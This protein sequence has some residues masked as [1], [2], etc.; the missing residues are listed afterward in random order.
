MGAEKTMIS[1]AV[2]QDE[3]FSLDLTFEAQALYLQLAAAASDSECGL[4][5]TARRAT[6]TLGL[7]DTTLETLVTAGYIIPIPGGRYVLTHYWTANGISTR[8]K[9]R[10]EEIEKAGLTVGQGGEYRTDGTG[11]PLTEYL[12]GRSTGPRRKQ[13]PEP[14]EQEEPEPEPVKVKGPAKIPEEL[15]RLIETWNTERP[16]H[17]ARITGITPGTLRYTQAKALVERY[18]PDRAVEIIRKALATPWMTA[19][20]NQAGKY[21]LTFD[22]VL[23][24]TH[25]ERIVEGKYDDGAAPAYP[26]TVQPKHETAEDYGF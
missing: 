2:V 21:W 22:W 7:S 25:T 17:L 18:G 15:T 10:T 19:G 3:R 23:D 9:Y 8:L 5:T 13:A 4:I 20:K 16:A 6:R 12:T 26:H 14:E 1:R 24:P 11:Q